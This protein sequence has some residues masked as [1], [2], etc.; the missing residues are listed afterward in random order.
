MPDRN[1]MK[2]KLSHLCPQFDAFEK[3]A[4]RWIAIG[5]SLPGAV[6]AVIAVMKVGRV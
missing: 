3:K 5:T 1:G 2:A 4:L 6:V